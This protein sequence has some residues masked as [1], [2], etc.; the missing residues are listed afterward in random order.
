MI[1]Y[2]RCDEN[3]Y[4]LI[5]YRKYFPWLFLKCSIRLQQSKLHFNW[6]HRRIYAVAFYY[7]IYTHCSLCV[8]YGPLAEGG[9]LK[10][11]IYW[12][13]L[14]IQPDIVQTKLSYSQGISS[15]LDIVT[16]WTTTL[17]KLQRKSKPSTLVKV[18]CFIW[19]FMGKNMNIAIEHFSKFCFRICWMTFE[20][21]FYHS[22]H[23]PVFTQLQYCMSHYSGQ[24]TLVA[25]KTIE[26]LLQ[27]G[28]VSP[29]L[30]RTKVEVVLKVTSSVFGME[31]VLH[32]R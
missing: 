23:L 22:P 18:V 16:V 12:Q 2:C 3:H 24:V 29:L 8:R 9:S 6:V 1:V 28:G 25:T 26:W 15:T 27:E 10:V 17:W 11:I 20:N 4:I 30:I 32:L 19:N 5:K 21:F 7:N 31:V 13:R 14:D